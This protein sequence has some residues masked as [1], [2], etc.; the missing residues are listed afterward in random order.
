MK[1]EKI[2]QMKHLKIN[3]K[4]MKIKT[5]KEWNNGNITGKLENQQ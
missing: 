3:N 2:K 4:Q 1:N 5:F